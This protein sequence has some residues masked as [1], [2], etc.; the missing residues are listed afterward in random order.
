MAVI[1]AGFAQANFRYTGGQAPTGAE[2]TLGLDVSSALGGPAGVANDLIVNYGNTI[3]TVLPAACVLTSVLVKFGPN[4]TGPSAEV[5]TTTP[6]T[7]GGTPASSAVSILVQKLTA[8]GGRPGRGRL[9]LPGVQESE[10]D[11]A[12]NL[13]GAFV[14]GLQDQFDDFFA[15]LVSSGMP[16]VLL[17]SETSPIATPTDVTGFA[18]QTVVAT[19]RRRQRR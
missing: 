8:L 19:Q 16:P 9:Y 1:P 12:G 14:D 3:R 18:V 13:S 11:E 10:V 15:E 7:G 5:G 4:T 2:W 17:H 6:G